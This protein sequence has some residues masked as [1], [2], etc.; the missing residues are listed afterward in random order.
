[1]EPLALGIEQ[2]NQACTSLT[3][4]FVQHMP[5]VMFEGYPFFL[6]PFPVLKTLSEETEL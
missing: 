6:I 5:R 2:H 1:M 3:F 4:Q